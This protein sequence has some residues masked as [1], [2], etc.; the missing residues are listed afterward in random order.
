VSHWA[1]GPRALSSLSEDC[2]DVDPFENGRFS[3]I[4]GASHLKC[5]CTADRMKWL[6][7]SYRII[8][9]YYASAARRGLVIREGECSIGRA[10]SCKFNLDLDL[11]S[12]FHP[13]NHQQHVFPGMD[14]HPK[15]Y[16]FVTSNALALRHTAFNRGGKH[17]RTG[18]KR[19]GRVFNIRVLPSC[20]DRGVY[21]L[22]K[23]ASPNSVTPTFWRFVS[24]RLIRV[25]G[26]SMWY[27]R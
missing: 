18:I 9:S 14:S 2:S 11:D 21:K 26:F 15:P 3:I 16:N 7:I 20:H 25:S 12:A 27:R 5:L 10:N 19:Q 24:R 23:Q 6:P 22:D 17:P 13:T 8:H 4:V 1:T